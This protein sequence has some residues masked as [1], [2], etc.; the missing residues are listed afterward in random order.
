MCLLFSNKLLA[1]SGRY[2]YFF[3]MLI[4]VFFDYLLTT[5]FTNRTAYLN[6]LL[7]T[8][9]LIITQFLLILMDQFY[10]HVIIYIFGVII[11]Y[12][13]TIELITLIIQQTITSKKRFWLRVFTGFGV[14]SS[15]GYFFFSDKLPLFFSIYLV[16]FFGYC[17]WITTSFFNKTILILKKQIPLLLIFFWL[18]LSLGYPLGIPIILFS[19]YTEMFELGWFFIISGLIILLMGVLCFRNKVIVD[20]STGLLLLI[21]EFLF[22]LLV[23]VILKIEIGNVVLLLMMFSLLQ[24]IMFEI[25]QLIS[26]STS[27][28]QLST[29]LEWMIREEEWKKEIANFLHDDLLQDINALIQL[30]EVDNRDTRKMMQKTLRELSSSIRNVIN[31][32]KPSLLP[33]MTLRNNYYLLVKMLEEKYTTKEITCHFIAPQNLTLIAPYDIF[34][35]RWIRELVNN[36]FKYSKGKSI[37]VKISSEGDMVKLIIM[38]DGIY[39]QNQGIILGHGLT[40]IREQ[41]KLVDGTVL[42]KQNGK[43]GLLIEIKF[44][45]EGSHSIESFINR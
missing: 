6:S 16:L 32:Y 39:N 1:S 9:R 15:L 20:H 25:K 18:C 29:G 34:V 14:A 22:G 12:R 26:I 41:L 31:E 3:F 37:E 27:K 4:L 13:L 19:T 2:H 24:Y 42:F 8:I 28:E 33:D 11:L 7:V 43:S 40:T 5:I 17:I 45:M 21:T 30:S 10:F 38:D 35:Y 44:E 36:A 23:G